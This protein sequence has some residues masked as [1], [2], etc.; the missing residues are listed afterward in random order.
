M[1]LPGTVQGSGYLLA[2][3]VLSAAQLLVVEL[4]CTLAMAG[5]ENQT[6]SAGRSAPVRTEYTCPIQ[7]SVLGSAALFSLFCCWL[8]GDQ[9]VQARTC[10]RLPL[11]G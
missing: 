7:W 10:L 3:R 9:D 8:V 5:A 4:T 6:T 2:G 1:L 11:T